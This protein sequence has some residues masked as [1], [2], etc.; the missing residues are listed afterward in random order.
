M[1]KVVLVLILIILLL[2]VWVSIIQKEEA[3]ANEISNVIRKYGRRQFYN[4]FKGSGI[5]LGKIR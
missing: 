1:K 4:N 5:Q 3:D 2:L